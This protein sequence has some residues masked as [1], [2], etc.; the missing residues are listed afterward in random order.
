MNSTQEY[1]RL[2]EK[3]KQVNKELF[4]IK[5]KKVEISKKV[6]KECIH[7]W[8]R[9]SDYDDLC[10]YMCKKCTLYNNSYLYE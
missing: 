9:C 10:K 7:E 6:W 1:L 4:C 8:E 2:I 3:E 5:L